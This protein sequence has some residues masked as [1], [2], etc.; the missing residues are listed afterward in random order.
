MVVRAQARSLARLETGKY[1]APM[2]GNADGAGDSEPTDESASSGPTR[3]IVQLRVSRF[4]RS[5]TL[6]SVQRVAER[7]SIDVSV[8]VDRGLLRDTIMLTL[9]GSSANLDDFV[10][11]FEPAIGPVGPYM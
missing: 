9:T 10:D 4:S 7:R 5:K 3:R 6:E 1:G 11:S 8:D 2:G